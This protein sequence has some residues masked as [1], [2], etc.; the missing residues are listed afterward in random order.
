MEILVAIIAWILLAII[1]GSIADKK[2]HNFALVFVLSVFLTPVI[3]F[4]LAI[5]YG[6]TEEHKRERIEEEEKIRLEVRKA[7]EN[8]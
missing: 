1:A 4:C 5:I 7:L 6:E 2:G 8:N 3:G